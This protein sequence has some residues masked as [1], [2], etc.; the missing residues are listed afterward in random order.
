MKT[1]IALWSFDQKCNETMIINDVSSS[2]L[3]KIL[4]RFLLIKSKR[5]SS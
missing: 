2:I 3:S 4:T 5:Q 1:T